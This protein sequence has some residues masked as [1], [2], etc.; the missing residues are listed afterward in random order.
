MVPAE[1][2]I[3]TCGIWRKGAVFGQKNHK[4][5]SRN[6]MN[7]MIVIMVPF[8]EILDNQGL[9]FFTKIGNSIRKENLNSNNAGYVI[10]G[11]IQ[12]NKMFWQLLVSFSSINK[13]TN[14]E[15]Y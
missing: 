3:I 14:H 2:F 7:N 8:K 11:T 12:A 4:F 1:K 15:F 6:T 5:T 10:L 9:S 13:F